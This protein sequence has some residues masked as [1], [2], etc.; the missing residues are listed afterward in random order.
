[1]PD[2]SRTLLLWR[3][4][5]SA[6][7]NPDLADIERPLAPRGRKSAHNMAAWLTERYQPDAV[8]CSPARRTCETLAAL[9][10]P[11][12]VPTCFDSRIYEA[13]WPALLSVLRETGNGVNTLLMVG[14]NP[15]LADLTAVLAEALPGKFPTG[16]C[17]VLQFRGEW[18]GLTPGCATL[19]AFQRQKPLQRT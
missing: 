15:G 19:G 14:H 9:H 16:A 17:A 13:E 12:T 3:H 7:E 5:K 1:M 18:S 11:H 6:W 10:L 2:A 8:I 4:A